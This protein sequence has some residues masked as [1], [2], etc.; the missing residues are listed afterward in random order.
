[1]SLETVGDAGRIAAGAVF[2]YV[3][4]RWSFTTKWGKWWD[5]RALF[6]LFLT[7]WAVILFAVVN[8]A[9]GWIP[10]E[11]L[12]L[13]AAIIW[14]TVFGSGLFLAIGYEVEQRKAARRRAEAEAEGKIQDE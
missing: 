10:P 6:I 2:L 7:I 3:W 13:V 4:V 11:W 1:M 9:L 14:F 12:P 8:N 5:T